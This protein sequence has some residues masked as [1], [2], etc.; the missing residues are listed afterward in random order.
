MVL[1]IEQAEL[2]RAIPR[3]KVMISKA[4]ALMKGAEA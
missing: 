3:V 1:E 4:G 2:E